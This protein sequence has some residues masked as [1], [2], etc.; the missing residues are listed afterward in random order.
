MITIEIEAIR[1]QK[2]ILITGSTGDIGK[3]LCK[4][5]LIRGHSVIAVGRNAQKLDALKH[6]F[7]QEVKSKNFST[8]SCNLENLEEVEL[9]CKKLRLKKIDRIYNVAGIRMPYSK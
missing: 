6:K 7:K 8:I 5:A 9:L 1:T 3:S 4:N 2:T